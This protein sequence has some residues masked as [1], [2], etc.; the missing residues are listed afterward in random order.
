MKRVLTFGLTLLVAGIAVS[1]L[2]AAPTQ[3]KFS[4]RQEPT[5]HWEPRS[6]A[7]IASQLVYDA[8]VKG[9]TGS[10]YRPQRSPA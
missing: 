10:V 6:S 4:P 9:A 8:G 2:A 3:R 1:L 7:A 5:G